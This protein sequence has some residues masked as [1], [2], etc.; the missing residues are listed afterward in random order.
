MKYQKVAFGT[1]FCGDWAAGVFAS[2]DCPMSDPSSAVRSCVDYV[3]TNPSMYREAYW[4]INSIRI[5]QNQSA[6][7]HSKS[8]AAESLTT[9]S[10]PTGVDPINIASNCTAIPLRETT[11]LFISASKPSLHASSQYF[12]TET[13]VNV[14]AG[15]ISS[16]SGTAAPS[17]VSEHLLHF[18]YGSFYA[19]YDAL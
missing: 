2:S 3:A 13:R 4:E 6:V 18:L 15:F 12:T 11:A 10:L 19:F 9:V 8:S 16:S 5:Y 17:R 14:D 1:T 7:Q